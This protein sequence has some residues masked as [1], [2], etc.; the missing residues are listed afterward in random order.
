MRRGSGNIEEEKNTIKTINLNLKIVLKIRKKLK[1]KERTEKLVFLQGSPTRVTHAHIDANTKQTQTHLCRSFV[2]SA[3]LGHF[4]LTDPL[5]THI[6][7]SL[8]FHKE[9]VRTCVSLCISEFLVPF[10]WLFFLFGCFV[11]FQ[12][13]CFSL[14]LL[15][16]KFYIFYIF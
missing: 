4:F 16:F 9:S 11:I 10:L 5:Y 3:K 7:S 14:I 8:G 6:A 15:V 2:H 12:F 1:K 13:L